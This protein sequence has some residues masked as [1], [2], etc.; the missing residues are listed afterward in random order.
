M[1]DNQVK[2]LSVEK[3]QQTSIVLEKKI[4]SLEK[5]LKESQDALESSKNEQT[6]HGSIDSQAI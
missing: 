4:E 5:Q 6:K 1:Q 2:Q 3:S